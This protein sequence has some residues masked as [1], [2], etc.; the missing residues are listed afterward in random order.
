MKPNFFDDEVYFNFF[1]REEIIRL[2][3]Q[4]PLKVS[5]LY[6]YDYLEKDGATSKEIFIFAQKTGP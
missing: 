1:T 5:K 6:E 3:S 4:Y 2:L